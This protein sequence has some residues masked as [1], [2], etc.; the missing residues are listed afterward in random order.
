MLAQDPAPR[1]RRAAAAEA[2]GRR[3]RRVTGCPY[4]G[5][6]RYELD[7]AAVFRGRER[8]VRTLVTA[9]VDRRLLVVSGSSGAG[10]SSV[11]RAGLLPALASGALPGS[12]AWRPS[13]SCP[14]SSRS[15]HSRPLTGEDPPATTVRARLRPARA[16]WSPE[17]APASGRPSST[18]CSGCWT[19]DVVARCVLVVRGDHVGR[20]AE[21]PDLAAHLHRRAGHGAADDR[22][23]AAPGRRGAGAGGRAARSSRSSPTSRCATS[24]ADRG[25]AAAVDGAGGDVGAAPRTAR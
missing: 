25:A 6:A 15:T 12:A 8:L 23:R 4:K 5:L 24:S 2:V 7:D 16:A 20:L 22:D 21:H 1:P 3:R 17:S 13:W 14:G 10:K 9:L 11:V 19:D 18:P